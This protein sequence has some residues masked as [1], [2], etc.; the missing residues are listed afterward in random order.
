MAF[1]PYDA[2]DDDGDVVGW[3]R[4]NIF[5]SAPW[6]FDRAL[7]RSAFK[8]YFILWTLLVENAISFIKYVLP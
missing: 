3:A 4:E 1:N 8:V 5:E 6:K 7:N 2:D